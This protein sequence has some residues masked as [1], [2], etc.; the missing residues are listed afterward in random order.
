[1]AVARREASPR[2]PRRDQSEER[3]TPPKSTMVV[4]EEIGVVGLGWGRWEQR[5]SEKRVMS[6]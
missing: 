2:C 4:V 3:D 1:M 6:S 5:G